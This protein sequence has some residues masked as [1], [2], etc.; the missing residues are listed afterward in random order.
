M[1]QQ[2]L[3]RTTDCFAAS[4]LY[5]CP[6]II[7]EVVVLWGRA[8]FITST[9]IIIVMMRVPMLEPETK[10][11]APCDYGGNDTHHIIDDGGDVAAESN[12]MESLGSA[13][14]FLGGGVTQAVALGGAV[15]IVTSI[16]T[17]WLSRY[18]VNRFYSTAT[19]KSTSQPH[20]A[21]YLRC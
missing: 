12:A 17:G 11:G 4:I 20:T 2:H 10:G 21:Q 18:F 3:D 14:L 1:M 16:E 19:S 6:I 8:G 9:I 7:N 13:L 5:L 15:D